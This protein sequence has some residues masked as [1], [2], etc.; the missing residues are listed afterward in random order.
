MTIITLINAKNDKKGRKIKY[1][2]IL[3]LNIYFFKLKI[4]MLILNFYYNKYLSFLRELSN[5]ALNDIIININF[6]MIM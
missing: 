6:E 5:C 3:E 4:L 2:S 1:R